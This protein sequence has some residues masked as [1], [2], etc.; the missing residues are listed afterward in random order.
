[1]NRRKFIIQG[2]MTAGALL[3]NG[4]AF[5]SS[6][7]TKLTILHTNDVHSRLDPFPMDGTRNAG[8]GGIAARAAIISN[9]RAQEA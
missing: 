2:G 4:S 3:L 7:S 5:A 6:S 9:I 8:M 1:M